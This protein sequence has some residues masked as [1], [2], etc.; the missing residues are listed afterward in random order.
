[1]VVLLALRLYWRSFFVWRRGGRRTG[2]LSTHLTK[3]QPF[4]GETAAARTETGARRVWLKNTSRI[5]AVPAHAPPSLFFPHDQFIAVRDVRNHQKPRSSQAAPEAL[6][7]SA[8]FALGISG[9]CRELRERD[10]PPMPL[11][12]R[13]EQSPFRRRQL[14]S[15]PTLEEKR[16]VLP[17]YAR[18]G[19]HQV[20]GGDLGAT[21]PTEAPPGQTCHE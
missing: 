21:A 14:T 12:Q 4:L 11:V 2:Q 20:R 10:D 3:V 15:L 9:R 5:H 7:K 8:Q 16:E 13:R 19:V 6:Y 1:M 17:I 18:I